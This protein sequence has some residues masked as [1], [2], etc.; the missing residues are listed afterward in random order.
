VAGDSAPIAD[1]E[2]IKSPR[3]PASPQ[4]EDD[5][6]VSSA[7][8]GLRHVQP[9]GLH[10]QPETGGEDHGKVLRSWSPC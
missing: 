3:V 5:K 2:I 9:Q 1:Q 6:A 8:R 4:H 7:G 10:Q